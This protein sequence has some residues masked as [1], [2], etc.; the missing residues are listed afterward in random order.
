MLLFLL[1]LA[2]APLHTLLHFLTADPVVRFNWWKGQP[3]TPGRSPQCPGASSVVNVPPTGL[4]S[5]FSVCGVRRGRGRSPW[6]G[7]GDVRLVFFSVSAALHTNY[8]FCSVRAWL[9]FLRYPP[10][11]AHDRMTYTHIFIAR[12][13][14][15]PRRQG[16]LNHA[17]Y[18]VVGAPLQPQQKAHFYCSPLN[19][20]LHSQRRQLFLSGTKE[21]R[22]GLTL[23]YV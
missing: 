13:E 21:S 7:T 15:V 14:K 12:A 18:R 20:T 5:A 3:A 22:L 11:R 19:T 16:S 23:V 9:S 17:G 8:I 10:G 6:G 2:V 1:V 4:S